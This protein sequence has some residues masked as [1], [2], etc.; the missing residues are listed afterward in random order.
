MRLASYCPHLST[1]IHQKSRAS[2]GRCA[3]LEGEVCMARGRFFCCPILSRGSL[4]P[5]LVGGEDPRAR[6]PRPFLL[7]QLPPSLPMAAKGLSG[8]TYPGLQ[9]SY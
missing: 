2:L 5:C 3:D 1:R 4:G 6:V 9:L 7:P 8:H